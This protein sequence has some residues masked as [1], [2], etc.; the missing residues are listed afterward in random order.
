VV[1][2][3]FLRSEECFWVAVRRNHTPLL[4]HEIWCALV[5]LT[6]QCPKSEFLEKNLCFLFHHCWC[7]TS[8]LYSWGYQILVHCNRSSLVLQWSL[9]F[10]FWW[11]VVDVTKHMLHW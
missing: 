9:S 11:N 10:Y 1:V 8:H 6:Y 4:S 7:T 3:V 2:H 5:F